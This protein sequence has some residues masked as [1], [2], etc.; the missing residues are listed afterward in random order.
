MTTGT[1]LRLG[2]VAD[3]AEGEGYMLT[4]R[5]QRFVH[6]YVKDFDATNAYIRAGY[7]KDGAYA[8]GSR[9]LKDEKIAALIEEEKESRAQVACLTPEW[10]LKQWMM[11]AGADPSELVK[12]KWFP[13]SACWEGAEDSA[14]M[15][16]N[17][18]CSRC[19]GE[20]QKIVSI[21]PTD[22]LSPAA[23]RLYAGAKQGKEGIEIKM[24]DQ[25]GALRSIAD[26]LGMVNRGSTALTGPGGGPLQLVTANVTDLTD[27][28]LM[29]LAAAG[30]TTLGVEPG[31]S[32][33]HLQITS[34]S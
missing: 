15:P 30:T 4:G 26:Y 12:V 34:G 20:G 6:E 11:I 19:K 32:E 33:A 17:P 3:Y 31:V 18:L 29:A 10:V 16:I 7:S 1:R 27:D 25:L 28:Q 14:Q 13:C 22:Q 24:H 21:T 2:G 9:L 23:R 8:G 5:Q